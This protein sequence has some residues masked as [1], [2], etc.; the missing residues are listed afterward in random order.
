[1]DSRVF[2]TCILAISI[3]SLIVLIAAVYFNDQTILS[4]WGIPGGLSLLLAIGVALNNF[5]LT[6]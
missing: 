6:D 4:F 3:S 5:E 1:M 2:Y